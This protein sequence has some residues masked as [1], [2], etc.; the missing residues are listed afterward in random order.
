M[1]KIVLSLAD[2]RN[3]FLHMP[4]MVMAMPSP[5]LS[6]LALKMPQRA[7]YRAL[8]A[9]TKRKSFAKRKDLNAAAA[10]RDSSPGR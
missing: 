3:P 1:I 9:K 4:K 10:V 2:T 7:S 8:T 6:P 5:Q